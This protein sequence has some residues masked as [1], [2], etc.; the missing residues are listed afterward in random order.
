MGQDL[1]RA[2]SHDSYIPLYV[3]LKEILEAHIQQN[4]WQPGDQLPSEPEL[5]NTYGISRT[6]VRQALQEMQ[7]EGSIFRKKGKGTFVAAPK[8][9]ESL[10][11]RLTGFY[12]DMV[13][14]GYQVVSQVLRQEVVPADAKVARYLQLE[15]GTKVTATTRLR[16]V[17]GEPINLVT[18][19][20]PYAL[21][22]Q[23]AKA[24]LRHQSLYDFLQRECGKTIGR[25]RRTIEAVLADNY[26]ADLL[27]VDVNAPLT[28][29]KG[30][31]YL[32]DGTPVEYYHGLH[33]S[34]RSQFE[35]QLIRVREGGTEESALRQGGGELPLT[36]E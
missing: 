10:V 29:V 8:Y 4:V 9:K 15:P 21:C 19:Y 33:R 18:A 20:I 5:C 11:Q 24:D 2:I 16:F 1:N 13:E 31:S 30:I 17:N 25:G 32:E 14:Q 7:R 12:Q 35:V 28:L 34:D 36:Q 6:V 3:Q 22:P 26:E 27:E 23:L